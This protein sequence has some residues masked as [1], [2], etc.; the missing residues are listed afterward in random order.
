MARVVVVGAGR[1]LASLLLGPRPG[2]IAG[3][4]L[5]LG[6]PRSQRFSTGEGSRRVV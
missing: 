1:Q 3:N 4:G 2:D 5:V 6:V